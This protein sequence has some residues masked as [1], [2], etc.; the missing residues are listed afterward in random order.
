MR[1]AYFNKLCMIEFYTGNI[2]FLHCS[3][4]GPDF[5]NDSNV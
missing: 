1:E 3:I 4:D 5:I 2:I